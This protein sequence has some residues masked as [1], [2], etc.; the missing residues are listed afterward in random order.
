MVALATGLVVALVCVRLGVWQV[1]R[2]S[3]RQAHNAVLAARLGDTAVAAMALPGDTAA[4]HY[5]LARLVG[6]ARYDRELAWA[7]RMRQGSPGVHFL[8]P[9]PFRGD[10]FILVDRGWAYSPDART[11]DFARWH[12]G[13]TLSV[14]GYAET[15]SQSCGVE[16]TRAVP[17]TCGDSATRLLRRLDRAA[18]ERFTGLRLAPYIVMQ[19]SDSALRADSVPVRVEP[20]V[21]DEGPHRGYAFQ[22][23]G[24]AIIALVGGVALA[25]RERGR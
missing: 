5:R 21:M 13:D 15:W 24:F 4:G 7:P 9:A 18:A 11:V 2:L 12:E 23:F 25:R 6:A 8:T 16:A 14:S 20:P 3:Q 10:T 1:N 22:W 17:A 19:T